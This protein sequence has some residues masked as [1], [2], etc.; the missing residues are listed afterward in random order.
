MLAVNRL[1][2][3]KHAQRL[4]QLQE[5]MRTAPSYIEWHAAAL[6]HDRYPCAAL[7]SAVLMASACS[8]LHLV[9]KQ[10]GRLR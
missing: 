6:E 2:G 9:P 7:V 10:T 8:F 4:A 5:L 3:K 1:Q